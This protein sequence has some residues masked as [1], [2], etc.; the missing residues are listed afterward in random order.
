ML[1]YREC[2]CY[3]SITYYGYKYWLGKNKSP[4]NATLEYVLQ[5]RM[6]RNPKYN[7]LKWSNYHLLIKIFIYEE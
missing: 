2:K 1:Q 5:L 6:I 4:P 3:F 7:K